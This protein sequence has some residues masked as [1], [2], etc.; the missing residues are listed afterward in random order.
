MRYCPACLRE[1]A[2][3][4][5]L[6]GQRAAFHLRERLAWR[7]RAVRLCPNYGIPLERIDRPDEDELVG[8]LP[9]QL[10]AAGDGPG[11]G[12]QPNGIEAYIAGRLTRATGPQW[13]DDQPL[14]QAIRSAELLGTALAFEPH[15]AFED[16]TGTERETATQCGWGF[17]SQADQELRQALRILEAR[18]AA[19]RGPDKWPERRVFG[20]LLR[21]AQDSTLKV[22]L[23]DVLHDHIAEMV[24]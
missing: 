5:A 23:W 3:A 12:A 21:E 20:N 19:P 7:F 6:T 1:D 11:A 16:L 9:E 24:G 18:A 13:L 4:A 14:G 8:A 2:E 15:D 17:V 10:I 22:P